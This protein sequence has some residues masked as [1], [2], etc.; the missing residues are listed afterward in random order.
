MHEH[1]GDC[2]PFYVLY[3]STVNAACDQ[4]V[5]LLAAYWSS[6]W[7]FMV[8]GVPSVVVALTLSAHF[9]R[10]AVQAEVTKD[11]LVQKTIPTAPASVEAVA[12]PPVNPAG[13]GHAT[14]T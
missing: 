5:R 10:A 3:I 11:S 7:W 6:V 14:G 1:I 12:D 8:L 4:G 13:P 2:R 9:A